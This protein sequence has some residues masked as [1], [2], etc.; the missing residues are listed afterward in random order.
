MV[1][2]RAIKSQLNNIGNRFRIF[3]RAEVKELHKIIETDESIMQ[4]AYGYYQ[5]G[6]GLLV[7]TDK[8]LLL[9]DKRPFYLSLE[10]LPFEYIKDI[11]FA[12]RLLQG[13]LYMHAGMK[14]LVF[15]S[16][17]D[18]RLRKIC[19]FVKDKIEQVEKPLFKP[20]IQ[21]SNKSFAGRK[22]YLNPAWRPHHITFAPKQRPSK[23]NRDPT[24][25]VTG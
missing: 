19:D 20:L 5:G 3:G 9:I 7:L 4:C 1:A 15:R 6:S 25:P 22:P 11:D 10:S 21:Q 16:V 13:T 18:A 17:S 2:K 12:A 14:R 8:R 24:R 23:F